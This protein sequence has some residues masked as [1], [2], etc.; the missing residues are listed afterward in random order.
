M[1]EKSFFSQQFVEKMQK[2]LEEY[3]A[4]THQEFIE[5]HKSGGIS[6]FVNKRKTKYLMKS[7]LLKRGYKV[8]DIFGTIIS[9]A[10]C[11]PIPII[12]I[13]IASWRYSLISLILGLVVA[14]I[15][16]YLSHKFILKNILLSERFWNYAIFHHG[17]GIKDKN[18]NKV[19]STSL[20]EKLIE[21]L[22][23]KSTESLSEYLEE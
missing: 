3:R 14:G 10:L 22:E 20:K 19:I 2:E 13:F 8:V 11:I 7:P 9:F 5:G 16:N 1:D 23:K 4:I 12:L 15:A 18:N 6:V 21:S 17:I